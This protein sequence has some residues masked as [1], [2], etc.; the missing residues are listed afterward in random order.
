MVDSSVEG[1]I[2]GLQAMKFLVILQKFV[3][4]LVNKFNIVLS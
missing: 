4:S 2:I 1:F 3:Q